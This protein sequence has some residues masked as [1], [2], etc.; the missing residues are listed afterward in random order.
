M[1]MAKNTKTILIVV[2]LAVAAYLAYR[3]YS[4]RTSSGNGSLGA[5]LNSAAPELV[6]GS[7]GPDSGL[8]YYAGTTP[9]TVDLPNGNQS[10]NDT[11]NAPDEDSDDKHVHKPPGEP[12][13]HGMHRVN[14]KCVPNKKVGKLPIGGMRTGSKIPRGKKKVHATREGNFGNPGGH[15]P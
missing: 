6:G 2:G 3:W 8:N 9:I 12:C 7:S 1:A 13:P 4:N 15:F 14:G 10:Q 5:N 11:E